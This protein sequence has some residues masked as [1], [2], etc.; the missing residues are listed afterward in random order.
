MEVFLIGGINS[1]PDDVCKIAALARG[2]S[3]DRI[4][5]NTAVRPP[6]EDFAYALSKKSMESLAYLFHPSA[7]IIAEFTSNHAHDVQV[8]Q[9]TIFSMLQRRPC[10]AEQIAEVFGM[11]L[12]EVSKYLGKL[13]RTDQIQTERKNT[14]VYYTAVAGKDKAVV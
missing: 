13:I 14:T 4:Q 2:I 5:L 6:A 12:N 11:H 3:P 10:T 8:N 1:T 9:E 7:Q